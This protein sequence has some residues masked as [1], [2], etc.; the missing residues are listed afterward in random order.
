MHIPLRVIASIIKERYDISYLFIFDMIYMFF[1]DKKLHK[2]NYSI[3]QILDFCKDFD[4]ILISTNAY[5]KDLT[6]YLT[7]LL[8][9]KYPQ[10]K[11]ILGGPHAIFNP[12]ECLKHVDY[13]CVWEG[14]N[15]ND[16]FDYIEGK[17]KKKILFNFRV[18][19]KIKTEL[20]TLKSLDMLPILDYE[21]STNYFFLKNKII[22]P[23][24]YLPTLVWYETSRG[25]MFSC[26]YCSNFKLNLI[27]KKNYL[28]LLTF[29]S[30]KKVINDLKKLL[31]INK[32]LREIN[33]TDDNFFFHSKEFLSQFVKGYNKYINK[34]LVFQIDPR[35]K[36]IQAK[37][38]I[39]M[40]VKANLVIMTGIQSG[41]KKFNKQVYNR[42][43]DYQKLIELNNYLISTSKKNFL[44][45]YY[46]IQGNPL[47]SRKD[48][49][50]TINFMLQL[51]NAVFI[52]PFY[53][54]IPNTPL[55]DKLEKE[56]ND[57]NTFASLPFNIFKK[58]AFYYFY[59]MI[60]SRFN[61]I[62]LGFLLPKKFSQTF[63]TEFLNNAF[64]ARLYYLYINIHNYL[65]IKQ[66]SNSII[67]SIKNK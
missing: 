35:A 57:L 61:Y 55:G 14:Y 49:L 60:I 21:L 31:E 9:I 63:F 38:K 43:H 66:L 65:I 40:N 18:K 23:Q 10:K 39:I 46:M 22:G 54:P 1:R 33:F 11:I 26:S 64:F 44:N 20:K 19:G 51:K 25:C 34:P 30:A 12:D 13:V 37:L 29:S 56:Y 5:D 48:V 59:S 53:T 3:E 8:K 2:T 36:D 27:K 28:P 32:Y 45:M 7:D 17:Y 15:I 24:K 41:S 52:I 16:L 67:L 4:Y 6:F 50:E 58:H 47:E 42:S 62:G